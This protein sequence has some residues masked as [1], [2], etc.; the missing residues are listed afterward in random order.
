MKYITIKHVQT[1]EQK[2]IPYGEPV[3]RYWVQVGKY[4][5]ERAE[6]V[7]VIEEASV[8]ETVE[9]STVVGGLSLEDMKAA[10]KEAGVKSVHLM[11]DQ[12][13][14]EKYNGLQN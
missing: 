7:E 10:L 9:E 1:N 11:G 2:E 12:T 8:V 6:V 13:I 3:P 5:F 4:P 14:I